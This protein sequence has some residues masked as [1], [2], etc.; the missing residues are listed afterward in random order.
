MKH[1]RNY[2]GF[3]LV[4]AFCFLAFAQAAIAQNALSPQ[5]KTIIAD[6]EKQA[7][8]YSKLRENLEEKLP[9]LSKDASAEQIEAHKAS[10]Q[11]SVQTARSGA[12]QGDIFT[13]AATELIR[14]IIKAE[15]NEKKERTEMR[16]TVSEADT[17]GV[18]LKINFPYPDSKEQIEMPP[19]LLL[20][21]PRLPKQLRFRFVGRNLVLVDRENALIIDYMSNALP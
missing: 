14:K 20:A 1:G 8:K 9:K 3:I 18:S 15:F 10:F 16:Q 11:K 19:T 5:E 7:E 12:K 17:K 2:Y 13:P 4:S 6:F 21:L